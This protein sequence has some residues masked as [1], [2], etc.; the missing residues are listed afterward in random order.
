VTV[1]W[2]TPQQGLSKVSAKKILSL[3]IEEKG[4]LGILI[5]HR[6]D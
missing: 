4:N 5:G 2:A 6:K 3:E 1:A